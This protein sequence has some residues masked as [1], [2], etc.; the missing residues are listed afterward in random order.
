MILRLLTFIFRERNM[1]ISRRLRF[2][3]F[4][5][6]NF[7]CKYCGR[8]SPEVVLELDHIIPKSKGGK[9][10]EINLITSCFECNR[11]K[12]NL[13]LS[14]RIIGED[15]YDKAIEILEK[16]RQLA[17]YNEV[18]KKQ[19]ERIDEDIEF[20]IEYWNAEFSSYFKDEWII[21]LKYFLKNISIHRLIENVEFAYLKCRGA[22]Y[23]CKTHFLTNMFKYFCGICWKQIKNE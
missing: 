8:K 5:R 16:E 14:E 7:T 10:D 9:S 11:G 17:E 23:D 2:E 22:K 20:F 1:G 12:G 6:D 4:K 19:N 3:V 18:I 13:N 15:P 21:S